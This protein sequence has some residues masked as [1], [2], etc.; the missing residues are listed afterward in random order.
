MNKSKFLNEKMMITEKGFTSLLSNEMDM[1][2]SAPAPEMVILG[3]VAIIPI[4]GVLVKHASESDCACGFVNYED[5]LSNIT[6]AVGDDNVTAIICFVDSPGGWAKG[7]IETSEEIKAL[8]QIKPIIAYSD[9]TIGSSAYALAS[10][11]NFIFTSPSCEVGGVG[12][13]L[14]LEIIEKALASA[15]I[16]ILTFKSG[17]YKDLYSEERNPSTDEKS[18]IDAGVQSAG[19]SFRQL[20]R[21]NRPLISEE[22]LSLALTYEGQDAIDRGYSDYNFNTINDLLALFAAPELENESFM[23][24]EDEVEDKCSKEKKR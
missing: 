6:E 12:S 2:E 22:D 17:K 10:S 9:T 20:I 13:I 23:E 15:G 19:E 14:K 1:A 8:A 21:Q 5:V 18:I 11:M 16:E 7:C 24:D 4:F 3:N